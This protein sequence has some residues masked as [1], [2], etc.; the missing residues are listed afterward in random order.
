MREYDTLPSGPTCAVTNVFVHTC[1]YGPMRSG[2][3]YGMLSR[4]SAIE[5][6][7]IERNWCCL[8]CR[9]PLIG[10]DRG[11]TC[12]NCDKHYPVID[13]VLIFASEPAGF[14]QAELLQIRRAAA[15]A[16]HR[17]ER[18]ESLGREV[19]LS[20]VSL[21]RC[22]EVIEAE[23]A[24]TEM[25]LAALEPAAKA[26]D[27][28]PASEAESVGVWRSSG[29]YGTFFPYLLR[30][31][32][33]TP[34]LV[35]VSSLID[36][37]VEEVVPDP[38]RKTIVFPGCGAGGLL[39]AIS[40]RF[41]R[42][43]GYDLALPMLCIAR[44]L[45][46][47]KGL[48]MILPTVLN[49]AGRV[50]LRK[51]D[52][53]NVRSELVAM[54]VLNTA[55]PD[56]SVDCVVTQFLI[57]LFPDPRKLADEVY[58]M[59]GDDG[60]WINFGPSGPVD[61]LRRFDETECAAFFEDSGFAVARSAAHRT[62]YLDL[63]HCCPSWNFRSQMCY[64]TSARKKDRRGVKP[65]PAMSLPDPSDLIP[66]HFPGATLVE[67]QS[68]GDVTSSTIVLRHERIQGRSESFEIG[69][70]VAFLIKFVDGKRSVQ[71]I[72]SLA[73]ERMPARTFEKN[74]GDLLAFVEQGLLDWRARDR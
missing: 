22:R 5:P 41:E 57:D 2:V 19:G 34:E 18:I 50:A 13:G 24:R 66:R 72:A 69:H 1:K 42:A 26:L 15:N 21:D 32:T 28:M 6:H 45:L 12:P 9:V 64:L 43:V 52:S 44:H 10:G 70:E 71:D 27:A 30:D 63:S 25:F 33:N 40:S 68:L 39:A 17:R 3:L 58:R 59:L 74:A 8:H 47:G 49:A 35:T 54:D 31:W 51:P 11:F 38:S 14:L 61:A 29:T 37:V 60:V 62:T 36:A 7:S 65:M 23:I 73:Q 67:R 16:R 48:D 53:A 4:M 56:G 20:A 46:D 55:F